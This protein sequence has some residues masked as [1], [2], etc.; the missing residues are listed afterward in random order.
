MGSELRRGQSISRYR[1]SRKER[2][3]MKPALCALT[4]LMLVAE[5]IAQQ[6]TGRKAGLAMA[7]QLSYE[8]IKADLIAEAE[9][10]P[11][12][13]YGFKPGSMPEVRTF[14]QVI[15]HVA[16]GQFGTCAAV[17][18]V[19]SPAAGRNLGQELNTKAES[20]KVLADSFA[21][22]DDVFAS[23]TDENALQF[24][25]QG[26]NELTRASILYGLLAHNAEMYG[27]GTVY[28]RLKGIVPPSTERQNQ[29]RAFRSWA[30]L[31]QG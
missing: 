8:G 29:R 11:E 24:V 25:R 15:T 22:C 1:D 3:T 6:P 23:T 28:L 19:P 18:G 21:F 26:P 13:D 9:R 10:M 16:A 12:A 27:I 5:A 30:S 31:R 7:L 4:A 2:R 14:G 20:V 17:K